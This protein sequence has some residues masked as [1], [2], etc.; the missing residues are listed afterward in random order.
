MTVRRKWGRHHVARCLSCGGT[1]PPATTTNNNDEDDNNNNS[2]NDN[3]NEMTGMKREVG[4]IGK[5]SISNNVKVTTAID[6][7]NDVRK[8]S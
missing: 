4:T 6:D 2:N 3:N 8:E 1:A 7:I 5:N